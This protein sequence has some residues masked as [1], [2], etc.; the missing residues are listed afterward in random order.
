M[1]SQVDWVCADRLDCR[2]SYS[3]LLVCIDSMR[4][5]VGDEYKTHILVLACRQ[6]DIEILTIC[7]IQS[8]LVGILQV[9]VSSIV[10]SHLK[11]TILSYGLREVESC[12]LS[13][14]VELR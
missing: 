2:T 5:L 14:W 1:S 4:A 8:L 11:V 9:R 12:R 10:G 3:V 7:D 6:C 13:D